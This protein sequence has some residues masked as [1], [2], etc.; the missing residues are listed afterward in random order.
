[1]D[2]WSERCKIGFNWEAVPNI[3]YTFTKIRGTNRAT[4]MLFVY[5]I[6]VLYV[7][8]ICGWTKFGGYSTNAL[9]GR[10]LD[11]EA[12]VLVIAG[13][14]P[15][16]LLHAQECVDVFWLMCFVVFVCFANELLEK[17]GVCCM[18]FFVLIS[19]FKFFFVRWHAGLLLISLFS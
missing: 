4:S 9:A 2:K 10:L 17:C 11:S 1:M 12:S 19:C 18:I 13:R 3:C 7:W 6:R 15:M 8:L 5:F 14:W 16:T